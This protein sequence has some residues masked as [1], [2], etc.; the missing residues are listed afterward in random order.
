MIFSY[1][2]SKEFQKIGPATVKE[3]NQKDLRL[4]G[5]QEGRNSDVKQG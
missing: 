2:E 1:R 3:S 5:L 4:S